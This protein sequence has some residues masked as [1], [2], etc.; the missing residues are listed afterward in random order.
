MATINSNHDTKHQFKK[1]TS[2]D[3]TK[4]T[5][6]RTEIE[7]GNYDRKKT[8]EYIGEITSAYKPYIHDLYE[9]TNYYRECYFDHECTKDELLMDLRLI[10]RKLD[11]FER[12]NCTPTRLY[13]NMSSSINLTTS[14][15]NNNSNNVSIDIAVVFN[16]LK[17]EVES[18]GYLPHS[19]IENIKEKISEIEEIC[20][21]NDT[22]PVK[23][24][25]LKSTFEWLTSK[26]VDIG[27]KLLPVI[28][29]AL[30]E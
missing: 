24:S 30:S 21:S 1:K 6:L 4:T 9:S 19:E 7:N 18:M 3:I 23:W 12:D 25:K 16:E 28:V 11:L 29:K 14:N 20:T 5:S 13:E 17:K 10:V 27:I 26:G 8:M 22:R 2:S 15:V